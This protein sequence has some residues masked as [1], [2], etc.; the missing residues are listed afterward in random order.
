MT[1][2]PTSVTFA[3]PYPPMGALGLEVCFEAKRDRQ[4]V[5]VNA[6]VLAGR[7]ER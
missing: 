5:G 7:P 6:L 1:T 4:R 3:T 2:T